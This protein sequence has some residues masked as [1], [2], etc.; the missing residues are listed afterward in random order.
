MV[1]FLSILLNF[2]RRFLWTSLFLNVL[3]YF[4]S[5][6]FTIAL[7]FKLMMTILLYWG[8]TVTGRGK[9]LVFYHNLGWGSKRLFFLAFLIDICLLLLIYKSLGAL[10]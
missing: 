9:E 7:S 4:L 1:N 2:Y 10:L 3:L 8:Y 5:F 6:S